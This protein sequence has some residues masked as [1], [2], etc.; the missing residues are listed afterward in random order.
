M[1]ERSRFLG[2]LFNKTHN[3]NIEVKVDLIEYEEDG[4]YYVYSPAFDLIGYGTNAIEARQSWETVL[5]EYFNYT[6]N[7]KSLIKDLEQRGWVIRRKKQF[8]APTFTW[9][10]QNNE[11]L[12]D[13]YNNHNFHK[14]T[15][16]ISVPL[17][18]A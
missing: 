2:R 1:K 12:S 4:I 8:K 11:Q 18:Y 13:I 3:S 5:E 10:L 7:K 17:A 14:I 6:L 16:P 9:M 15:Q